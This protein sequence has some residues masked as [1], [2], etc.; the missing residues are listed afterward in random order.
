MAAGNPHV[1]QLS[2]LRY[3]PPVI[4]LGLGEVG[5]EGEREGHRRPLPEG[6]GEAAID[7][8][9]FR[10]ARHRDC[11]RRRTSRLRSLT[12]IL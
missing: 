1:P 12:G 8:G 4:D 10:G 5:V 7:R 11:G 2:P 6:L 9:G 3:S